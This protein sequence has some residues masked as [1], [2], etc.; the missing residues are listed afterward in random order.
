MW[1]KC[2]LKTKIDTLLFICTG[3]AILSYMCYAG[4]GGEFST[5]IMVFLGVFLKN[6]NE[7]SL[8][9]LQHI[10]LKDKIKIK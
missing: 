10:S 4:V 8:F 1:Y 7:Y 3:A 2:R 9:K 6:L 5:N